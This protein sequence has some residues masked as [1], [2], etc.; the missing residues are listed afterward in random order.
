MQNITVKYSTLFLLMLV[1]INRGIFVTPYEAKNQRGVEINSV[2][3]WIQQIAT[4]EGND[5]DEDDDMQTDCSFTNVFIH[6]F[7]QQSNQI[8]PVLKEIKQN[9][10]PNKKNILSNA[11]CS[12]ID[13]PPEV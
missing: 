8:N 12:Q 4:G 13:Q 11:F 9:K 3:E 1:Y 2:I 7:L 10:F 6:D 5:I